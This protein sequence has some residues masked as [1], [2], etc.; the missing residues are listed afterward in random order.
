MLKAM[1]QESTHAE[2]TEESRSQKP[3]EQGFW[4]RA[5]SAGKV[6]VYL[7]DG[8]PARDNNIAERAAKDMVFL[9]FSERSLTGAEPP[10]RSSHFK[11]GSH[12][13]PHPG[14]TGPYR[15]D[16]DLHSFGYLFVG[17]FAIQHGF[18]GGPDFFRK[19]T[20]T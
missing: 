6:S 16:R 15:A 19:F 4:V 7:A 13:R 11:F 3:A 20:K 17:G 18:K 14:N 12:C 2:F 9:R 1:V 8:C 5:W 10:P